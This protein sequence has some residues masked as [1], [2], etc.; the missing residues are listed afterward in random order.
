MCVCDDR[1]ERLDCTPHKKSKKGDR[2]LRK[3]K[4]AQDMLQLGERQ[5]REKFESLD[6]DCHLSNRYRRWSDLSLP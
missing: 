4:P 6:D 2:P 1:A 5:I 3:R